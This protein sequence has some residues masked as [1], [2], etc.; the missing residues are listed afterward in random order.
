M[1][2]TTGIGVSQTLAIDLAKPGIP[3]VVYAMQGEGYTRTV[4]L[5]ISD[6]G[7]EWTPPSDAAYQVSYCKP[8]GKGGTYSSYT[9]DST[10]PAVEISGGRLNVVLIPQMLQVAGR[11]RVEVH[12]QHA[13]IM[14][15]AERLSTFTFY[16]MVQA[17]AESG[18][19]STDYWAAARN[20][21]VVLLADDIGAEANVTHTYTTLAA[22]FSTPHV[23]DTVV[24][25]DGYCG[26]VTEAS[27]TNVVFVSTGNL[28][29]DFAGSGNAVPIPDGQATPG[30]LIE[31]KNVDGH[32]VP[33]EWGYTPN[34][35]LNN[36]CFAPNTNIPT[37]AGETVT[38]AW[39]EG[40]FPHVPRVDEY[41]VGKNG[42]YGIVT[43]RDE[44]GATKVT[45]R[46]SG[47]QFVS[48]SG[49]L[50]VRATYSAAT[51]AITADKTFSEIKA[52]RNAGQ[53]VIC[54]YT[55]KQIMLGTTMLRLDGT[56]TATVTFR[57]AVIMD[58]GI[59]VN[60]L[61]VNSSDVWAI[62]QKQIDAAMV[63]YSGNIDKQP[64]SSV[65]AALDALAAQPGVPGPKGDK[66]DPGPQG[67]QGPQGPQGPQGEK[68]DPGPQG[69]KGD[70][71]D[72]GTPA[73]ISTKM[74][75]VNPTGSGSFQMNAL[76]DTVPGN[77]S[78]A[79]GSQSTASGAAAHA[80]GYRTIASGAD[81]H[82]EGY[83][84][85][86]EGT[87]SH[88]EGYK[89]KA[90]QHYQHVQGRHN[91]VDENGDFVDIV[92]GGS[93]A[94]GVI[95][96]K[97]LEAT[98][99]LGDKKMKGN[100]YVNC[101]DDSTGGEKLATEAYVQEHG[102]TPGPKGDK[103][104]PGP[105]GEQGPKGDKGDPG[106]PG[107]D[108]KS[109][110]QAA[111]DGG[112]T[113]DEATFNA[114]LANVSKYT[115]AVLLKN[116]ERVLP[117]PKNHV[118]SCG[119]K[120]F[121]TDSDNKNKIFVSDDAENWTEVTLPDTGS[122]K[123]LYENNLF[124]AFDYTEASTKAF[125]SAD[126]VTWTAATLPDSYGKKIGAAGNGKFVLAGSN[127][128]LSSA[129]AITWSTYNLPDGVTVEQLIY[130]DKFVALGTKALC[131]TDGVTWTATDLPEGFKGG[132]LA[133]GNGKYVLTPNASASQT[134]HATAY[135]STDG[136]TWQETTVPLAAQ[137]NFV[138]FGN[139]R[140]VATGEYTPA[141][142]HA[143]YSDDGI[144]WQMVD[145]PYKD[146]EGK[147]DFVGKAFAFGA[148]KFVLVS[149]LTTKLL[150]SVDGA[151]W[152][153]TSNGADRSWGTTIFANGRFLVSTPGIFST[154]CYATISDDG[155]TWSA[156]IRRLENV[157][158]EDT[159]ATVR[160]VLE[161]PDAPLIVTATNIENNTGTAD[162]SS[163]EILAAVSAGREV[164]LRGSING[165]TL[166][167][168]FGGTLQGH[169]F[170]YNIFTM[171]LA[172]GAMLATVEENQVYVNNAGFATSDDL[173]VFE[174]TIK[175]QLLPEVTV[176]DNGKFAR[177][178]NGAWAAQALTNV[179]EVGA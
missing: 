122:W 107:A 150:Y 30:S 105:Q 115:D 92:G 71:G 70:K 155:V 16:V 120:F 117:V 39:A 34:D 130:G 137:W 153:V 171:G 47:M 159:T 91:V 175:P 43:A 139:G 134:Y 82:A 51:N 80:E 158:G 121:L 62:T 165:I 111:Q 8:D 4:S 3:K 141:A 152:N 126:A 161:V 56:P 154:P 114:D 12:M 157:D 81:S 148:G 75:K 40:I 20:D 170:F 5:R 86:A 85:E 68:G 13:A 72:P 103:G 78:F 49:V 88:A 174:N 64:V 178:V 67:A 25:R 119:E 156:A 132:C 28:W 31:V 151:T 131:S 45:V 69:P 19:T 163:S 27:G 52:A 59:T 162:Y 177:V 17:S 7:V 18:I 50:V 76:P 10:K 11:V 74:D 87:G 136:A 110:Y 176:A 95:T 21:K 53:E 125:Y 98:T 96:R 99:T 15:Y 164:Y 77:Y 24:G 79:E 106:A 44:S 37:T 145:L 116:N 33:T 128:V 2:T 65:K 84:S 142:A 32:Y 90:K 94:D 83:M 172:N 124:V 104:D 66:G 123:F 129:D 54:L 36:V 146:S 6:D 169:P 93:E 140:F 173:D 55:G 42:Y 57:S 60:L 168:A 89:T 35:V 127:K 112:F 63:Q 167:F 58:S 101:N 38:I 9:T 108:G 100:V 149:P 179:S 46:S 147:T 143:I 14:P 144:T 135:Y 102:G 41:I 113:G 97:N 166:V 109:A 118:Y 133:Y 29:V 138:K 23:G 61:T 26:K 73:D 160:Q 1:A 22:F 48:T